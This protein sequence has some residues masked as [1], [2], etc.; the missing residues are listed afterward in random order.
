MIGDT[1]RL[2]HGSHARDAAAVHRRGRP[3][4]AAAG[5]HPSRDRSAG[6]AARSSSIAAPG[7]ALY[8]LWVRLAAEIPDRL[9]PLLFVGEAGWLSGDLI[10]II[11]DDARVCGRLFVLP[12]QPDPALAWLYRNCAF[13]LH[14]SLAGGWP[15]ALVES[16]ALGKYCVASAIP[17]NAELSQGLLDLLDPFDFIAWHDEV[18]RL[19]TEPDRLAAR[20]RRIAAFRSRAWSSAGNAL[21]AEIAACRAAGAPA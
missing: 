12:D 20:E 10:G 16:L 19:M 17:A 9:I 18:R 3:A 14:P 13:T 15:R 4:G 6:P 11:R 1:H 2:R 7:A 5:R 21:A 8:D